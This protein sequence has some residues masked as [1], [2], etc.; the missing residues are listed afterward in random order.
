VI[1]ELNQITPPPNEDQLYDIIQE[2]IET[3]VKRQRKHKSPGIDD[4]TGEMI[5]VGGEKV[6]CAIKYGRKEE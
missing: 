3:A 1:T 6:M 5:Q 2:E 4:I